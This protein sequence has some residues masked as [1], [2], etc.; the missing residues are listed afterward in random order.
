MT[1]TATMLNEHTD[2]TFLYICTKIKPLA[3][4]VAY[5]IAKYEPET[6]MPLK[7]QI[8]ATYAKL[9]LWRY[10]TTISV[11]ISYEH[12]ASNSVT[13]STAIHIFHIICI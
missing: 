11:Y 10:Q 6:N 2:P 8:Y 9:Y 12:T 7:W 1:H 13:M 5:I 4:D 3:T